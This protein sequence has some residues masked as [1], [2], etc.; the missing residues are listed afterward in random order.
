MDWFR[1]GRI[2]VYTHFVSMS[3]LHH[4]MCH[5]SFHLGRLAKHSIGVG[6]GSVGNLNDGFQPT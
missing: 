2:G 1:A 3:F 5:I 4:Y 6:I